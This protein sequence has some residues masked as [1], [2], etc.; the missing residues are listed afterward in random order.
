MTKTIIIRNFS[1]IPIN[2][3][4]AVG[5]HSIP[6]VTATA[7]DNSSSNNIQ[8]SGLAS[9]IDSLG[10][11]YTN[12]LQPFLNEG[13]FY[14][15]S[16]ELLAKIYADVSI[17]IANT[18]DN[19]AIMVYQIF[20]DTITVLMQTRDVYFTNLMLTN[21][22]KTLRDKYQISL[23]KIADLMLDL[24]KCHNEEHGIQN[25]V[26]TGNLGIV[27]NQPKQ[28]IYAQ[29]IMNI[30]LAWYYY[31]Y[32]KTFIDPRLYGATINYVKTMGTKRDAYLKLIQ[33]LDDKYKTLD[34][35]LKTNQLLAVTS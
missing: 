7:Y 31:L 26:L 15:D 30:N 28:L 12:F 19:T 18:I 32:N 33:L 14:M 17:L 10:I 29:A 24:M 6:N 21:E 9:T 23:D 5:G 4:N 27:I 11:L 2:N 22:V 20:Q 34:D 35:N 16:N 3:A 8:N 1:G 25:A 13:P